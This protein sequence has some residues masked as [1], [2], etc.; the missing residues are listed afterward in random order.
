MAF[1][2]PASMKTFIKKCAK[3]ACRKTF[4][5]I[6][7]YIFD[8]LNLEKIKC[9]ANVGGGGGGDNFHE[10][11]VH[12]HICS[13]ARKECAKFVYERCEH[14]LFC[15]T[16]E[17]VLRHCIDI[18]PKEGLICEFG[19]FRGWSINEIANNLAHEHDSRR[20]HGFD[21]FEGLPD[22]W[23]GWLCHSPRGWLNADG[24]LPKVEASVVLHKGLIQHTLPPFLEE[25]KG[26]N[27]AFIHADVD[28]YSSTKCVL[29][30]TKPFVRT[31]T[32]IL[33][34]E[35]IGYPGWKFGEYKALTETYSESEYEFVVFN[36][37]RGFEAGIRIK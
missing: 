16:R 21:S 31:G 1:P 32:I 6:W 11:S 24:I 36:L 19:V 22:E 25:N 3:Y 12:D 23:D 2:L 33:F 29:E 4:I 10:M 9:T 27:I 5:P 7:Q 17:Q 26:Q 28:I 15:Y 30:M 37:P 20:V 8:N 14:A 18:M 35:L 34:D 13:I